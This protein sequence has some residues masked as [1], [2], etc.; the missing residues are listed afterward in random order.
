MVHDIVRDVISQLVGSAIG[1]AVTT[2]ATVGFGAP[3]AMAQFGVK[4]AGLVAKVGRIIP[5]VIDALTELKRLLGRLGPSIGQAL[6]NLTKLLRRGHVPQAGGGG[7][8]AGG[9]IPWVGE[10]PR[11]EQGVRLF[12]GEQ[13]KYYT[14]PGSVLGREGSA[15]FVMPY[16]DVAKISSPAQAMI[17]SGMAPS[18]TEAVVN[19]RDMYAAVFDTSHLPQRLP[20][21][22][23]AG[24]FEHFLPG[25]RTAVNI[26]GH[27]FPNQTRE[28][29]VDG[30]SK[31]GPTLILKLTQDE[32]WSVYGFYGGE[33]IM[34]QLSFLDDAVMQ[35]RLGN[36]SFDELVDCLMKSTV[37]MPSVSDP[38]AAAP[39]PVLVDVDGSPHVVVASSGVALKKT[40]DHASFAITILGKDVMLGLG[41][42]IGLFVNTEDDAFSISPDIVAA[43]KSSG[44]G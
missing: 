44:G 36:A 19:G 39:S 23:D 3:A 33:S 35:V 8:G 30:G 18:V 26:D 28:F 21:I 27:F 5:R 43:L 40:A 42:G 15:V 10:P 11:I 20:T 14:A 1:M 6:D 41:V 29:V 38:T 17:E 13:L 9:G 12:G 16:E 37:A 32:G 25:G 4:V 31:L 22:A 24:G 2:A 34:G 7:H